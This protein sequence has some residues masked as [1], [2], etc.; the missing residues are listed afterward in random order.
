MITLDLEN[1][2]YEENEFNKLFDS[3][4]INNFSYSYIRPNL[5]IIIKDVSEYFSNNIDNYL[6]MKDLINGVM[7]TY[8]NIN[9]DNES[10]IISDIS[11][12]MIDYYCHKYEKEWYRNI[13]LKYKLSYNFMCSLSCFIKG[14]KIK[15]LLKDNF[16]ELSF[17]NLIFYK[18]LFEDKIYDKILVSKVKLENEM[19][20]LSKKYRMKRNLNNVIDSD[21]DNSLDKD[22][23]II[24]NYLCNNLKNN[25]Y[26][27][28]G[29]EDWM[30]GRMIGIPFEFILKNKLLIFF[31]VIIIFFYGLYD[32]YS[33]QNLLNNVSKIIDHDL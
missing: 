1:P 14:N 26:E 2:I 4:Q 20:D 19:E 9:K 29:D 21:Y 8:I 17:T 27:S 25:V 6:I 24:N 22:S 7:G 11:L 18:H 31:F 33:N 13:C 30:N 12:R 16:I 23:D 3:S 28:Y 5:N 15:V 10:D 32:E